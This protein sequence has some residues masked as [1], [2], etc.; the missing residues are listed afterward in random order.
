MTKQQSSSFEAAAHRN[1]EQ[2]PNQDYMF[3]VPEELLSFLASSTPEDWLNAVT[4]NLDLLL[5][6]HANCEK[7]AAATAMN[8]MYRYVGHTDLL[9]KMSQLAREE[10]LHFQ[11]VVELMEERKVQYKK[12]SP[13][14]Y[15]SSLRQHIRTNEKDALV[16]TL[17]IGAFIEAR[18][19]ERFAKLLPILEPIDTGLFRYYRSLLK[20]ESRHY[21]DYLSLAH[22]YADEPLTDRVKF[23]GEQESLL[24]QSSDSQFRFHSGIPS[25]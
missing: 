21:Q 22:Q 16:D 9:V 8:L 19:C 7:K 12:L 20:S 25:L 5:I 23:Y 24:I 4:D 1:A 17:I 18:S 14:R 10:L 15:A 11:Q 6:D 3:L 2:S 13:A